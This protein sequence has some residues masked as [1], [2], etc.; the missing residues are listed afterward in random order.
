MEDI[1]S[2]TRLG[3]QKSRVSWSWS[4]IVEDRVPIATTRRWACRKPTLAGF[5]RSNQVFQLSI[6]TSG[7]GST[8]VQPQQ[9]LIICQ[10]SL[11]SLYY[12]VD[13][14]TGWSLK[15][16]NHWSKFSKIKKVPQGWWIMTFDVGFM[17]MA[18][19]ISQPAI[20]SK[21][22]K[23]RYKRHGL[24]HPIPCSVHWNTIILCRSYRSLLFIFIRSGK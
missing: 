18:L 7:C 15:Y 20:D 5:W 9:G 6:M 1:S 10:A 11:V 22:M 24:G 21:F 16:P 12:W 17:N 19:K 23:C 13:W 2:P 14:S 8:D 4:N 3:I